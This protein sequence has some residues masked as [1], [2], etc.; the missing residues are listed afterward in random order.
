MMRRVLPQ[1]GLYVAAAL[2]AIVI[3][4]PPIWL[5]ISSISSTAELL[6]VPV[7]W[8]PEAPTLE[9]YVQIA[10]ATG[11]DSAAN[12]R[13]S[14]FNSL[15]IAASVTAI[16]VTVGALAAYSF[17]RM[18]FAGHG[19]LVYVL[20]IS[21]TL[22]PIMLVIPLFRVMGDLQLLDTIQGL[23]IVYSSLIMPFAIWILRS[24]FQTIPA[25][26]EDAAMIDGCTRLQALTRVILPISLPGIVATGLFCF[27]ASWEEFL[28]ALIFTSS[29]TAKTIPVAIA[30]FTGRHAID[31][32]M[33]ATGGVIAA[34]PPILIALLF[35]RYLI[36]GLASGAVKG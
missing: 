15:A 30:E 35:Q 33:M 11:G 10:T 6:R 3:L 2:V 5:L 31:Y 7:H 1:I 20:L 16:C 24:Y 23:V 17:A 13:R 4:A 22:P 9:R 34:L 32:G 14:L 8:I 18:S 19:Q 29:P 27:L 12:F 25:D 28:I 21:Y 26:L 36:S